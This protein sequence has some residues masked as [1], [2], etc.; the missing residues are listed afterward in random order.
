MFTRTKSNTTIFCCFST[1][2]E[3]V[4]AALLILA[5]A[6]TLGET[7]WIRHP[8]GILLR[9]KLCPFLISAFAPDLMMSPIV[10]FLG[11]KIYE[12]VFFE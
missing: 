6:L 9:G 5:F 8:I 11:A 3:N 7:L 1:N 2:C 4:P 10:V 12:K